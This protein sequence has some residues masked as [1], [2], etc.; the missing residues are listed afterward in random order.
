MLGVGFPPWGSGV[1]RGIGVTIGFRVRSSEFGGQSS[2]PI[3]IG[4]RVQRSED[5]E[6]GI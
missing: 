6:Q 2:D 5:R 1:A 4:F 3:A